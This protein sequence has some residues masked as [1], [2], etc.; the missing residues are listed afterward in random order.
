MCRGPRPPRACR[1]GPAVG[2]LQRLRGRAHPIPNPASCRRIRPLAGSS[3]QIRMGAGTHTLPCPAAG[4]VVRCPDHPHQ[5]LTW[6]LR[7]DKARKN[8]PIPHL[9][10]SAPPVMS[11]RAVEAHYRRQVKPHAEPQSSPFGPGIGAWATAPSQGPAVRAHPDKLEGGERP[12]LRRRVRALHPNAD[13]PC[14]RPPGRIP[15]HHRAASQA[16]RVPAGPPAAALDPGPGGTGRRP[17]RPPG[18]PA[19]GRPAAST[20]RRPAPRFRRNQGVA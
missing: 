5:P 12:R 19:A 11:P 6:R 17:R 2:G 4:E 18:R 3:T 20:P 1:H 16:L 15:R 10:L 7:T 9:G 8:V 13:R 14:S